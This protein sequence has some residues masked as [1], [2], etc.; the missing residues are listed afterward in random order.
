[1]LTSLRIS[2]IALALVSFIQVL[3]TTITNVS[4]VSIAGDLGISSDESTWVVTSFNISLAIGLPLIIW[5]SKKYG[6]LCILQFSLL[7]FSL[8]SFLCCFPSNIY[9]LVL[10]R[11][12]HGLSAAALYPLTQSLLY[13]LYTDKD[14]GKAS[15]MLSMVTLIAPVLGPLLGGWL[16]EYF[17][18]RWVF[19]INIPF[20]MISYCLLDRFYPKPNE[21]KF[22]NGRL[23]PFN[24]SG[25]VP[26]ACAIICLQIVLDTGNQ[27]GWLASGFILF[28][29]VLCSLSLLF[30]CIS[31][32]RSPKKSP[33][34]KLSLFRAPSYFV[35]MTL[36][37]L[38]FSVFFLTSVITAIWLRRVMEYTP[39][40]CGIAIVPC[41]IAPILLSLPLGKYLHLINIKLAL[42]GS[43]LVLGLSCFIRSWFN[44][45]VST[46]D[47]MYAQLI[48]GLSTAPFFLCSMKLIF[49]SIPPQDISE[50]SMQATFFRLIGASFATSIATYIWNNRTAVH[51]SYLS[52]NIVGSYDNNSF[53][54]VIGQ[55]NA[56]VGSYLTQ[57][58]M[59]RQ[60]L[61][62]GFNDTFNLLGWFMIALTIFMLIWYITPAVMKLSQEQAA[63]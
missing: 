20:C 60:A 32:D 57:Q 2:T 7:S 23:P 13:Y 17:S 56:H 10:I 53:L 25:F 49:S 34:I 16:T 3:D 58:L 15:G 45:D 6:Q 43:Y 47:I 59:Y 4:L 26:L 18:W 14:R 41:G 62:M 9:I 37:V 55:G 33:V 1:M 38:T 22:D 63:E 11:F 28:F 31:I 36:F 5:L 21:P 51:F 30:Y 27:E 29:F 61:Q 42:S 44:L 12:F 54:Y 8:I 35:G 52:E 24:I 39:I 48:L 46:E 19:L 50:A 40:Q